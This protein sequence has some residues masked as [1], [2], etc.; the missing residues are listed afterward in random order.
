VPGRARHRQPRLD[1]L[2]RHV[3]RD[4]DRRLHGPRARGA[5]RRPLCERCP[6]T[7]YSWRSACARA[8]GR[9][10]LA[11]RRKARRPHR[12]LARRLA[13][14]PLGGAINRRGL[15]RLARQGASHPRRR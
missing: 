1:P 13:V 8:R 7:R 4:A 11:R 3:R 12:R 2:V 6:G 14:P 9:D 5:P 10:G 15:R